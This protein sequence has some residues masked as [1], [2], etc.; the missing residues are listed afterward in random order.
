MVGAREGWLALQRISPA[1]RQQ[2]LTL[3][4]TTYQAD[5]AQ[6][7]ELRVLRWAVNSAN[8]AGQRVAAKVGFHRVAVWGPFSR[9]IWERERLT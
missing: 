9:S 8:T 2:G 1:H 4:L 7:A 6:K 3:A 5:R